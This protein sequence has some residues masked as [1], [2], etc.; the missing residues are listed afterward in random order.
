MLVEDRRVLEEL[1]RQTRDALQAAIGAR[2]GEK[3]ALLDYPRHDNAGDSIIWRGTMAYLGDLQYD[4]AHVS[5]LGRFD[6]KDLERQVPQ[7]PLLL[8]GG[9]NLGD[10]WPGFQMFRESIVADYPNRKIV[11]L[12]Q[13]LMFKDPQNAE[14][15]RRVFDAHPDLTLL[16]RDQPSMERAAALFR[17]TKTAYC[18]DL[19]LGVGPQ[20]RRVQPDVDLMGLVRRD[21]ESTGDLQALAE[22]RAGLVTDWALSG[23]DWLRW[24]LVKAPGIAYK[25]VPSQARRLLQPSMRWSYD[26]MADF[27]L[28]RALDVLSRGHVVITDRLHAHVMCVLLGIPHVVLDNNYGKVSSIY[29]DYTGRFSTARLVRSPEEATRALDELL[30]ARATA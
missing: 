27:N 21:A 18:P 13:T 5:D 6:P 24:S 25:R 2:P 16:L 9:G 19:A 10:L 11:V 4:V 12:A 14:R 3:V 17:N 20:E 28:R 23:S 29:A 26:A 7:G 22:Q 8:Q 30:Q 15:A 1:R